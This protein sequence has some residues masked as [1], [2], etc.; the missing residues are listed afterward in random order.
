MK[1]L[2]MGLAAVA[3]AAAAA[4]LPV[5]A[6]A[7]HDA[8]SVAAP[9][10]YSINV[11]AGIDN[12]ANSQTLAAVQCPKGVVWGGGMA[13]Q[14]DDPPGVS[15]N[16]SAPAG[17]GWW[18]ARAN[19][20]TTA[21]SSFDMYALC[22]KRPS[23]YKIVKASANVPAGKLKSVTATCPTGTVL[24]SGGPDA[25]SESV[26]SLITTAAPASSTTFTGY[27]SNGSSAAA[28][29]Q[30]FAICADKPAGW[31][32]VKQVIPASSGVSDGSVNC[33]TNTVTLGGGIALAKHDSNVFVTASAPRGSG[34]W[35]MLVTNRTAGTVN[36]T[37]YAICG[38]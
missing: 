8:P 24:L 25:A 26:E 6:S 13:N 32:K 23:G 7:V 5:S 12:P 1:M 15:I 11:D 27:M 20:P 35:S 4:V 33:P 36:A 19:N 38:R 28:K 17:K 21:D 34:G 10:G 37:V 18:N 3:A 16:I 29:L 2:R 14:D 30:V 31:A 22:A 9:A